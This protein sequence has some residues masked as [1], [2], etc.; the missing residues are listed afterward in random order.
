MSFEYTP[1]SIDLNEIT[2]KQGIWILFAEFAK[3]AVEAGWTAEQIDL[4]LREAYKLNSFVAKRAF[5]KTYCKPAQSVDLS[6]LVQ[7]GYV[8]PEDDEPIFQE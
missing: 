7:D 5:L 1:L 8:W 4:V 6:A 3:T 2:E